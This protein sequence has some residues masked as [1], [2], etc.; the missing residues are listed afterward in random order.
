MSNTRTKAL[1]VI[2]TVQLQLCFEQYNTILSV[3]T[4]G[5]RR[6]CKGRERGNVL[7]RPYGNA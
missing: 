6:F 3:S 7:L 5:R 4:V 2:A 1:T